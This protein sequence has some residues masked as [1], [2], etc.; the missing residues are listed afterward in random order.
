MVGTILKFWI[1]FQTIVALVNA[2][3]ITENTVS[4]GEVDLSAESFSIAPSVF[5]TILNAEYASLPQSVR[6]G[7]ESGFYIHANSDVPSLWI[8]GQNSGTLVNDGVVSFSAQ[9]VPTDFNVDLVLL[10]LT[11]NGQFFVS[12]NGATGNG[13]PWHIHG[14]D[15]RNEGMISFYQSVPTTDTVELMG[16]PFENHGDVCIYNRVFNV[17]IGISG[18]GCIQLAEEA[19]IVLHDGS[20]PGQTIQFAPGSTG[21]ILTR[22][23]AEENEAPHHVRGFGE[24]MAISCFYPLDDVYYSDPLVTVMYGDITFQFDIGSGYDGSLFAIVTRDPLNYGLANNAVIYGGPVPEQAASGARCGTCVAFVDAPTD[25]ETPSEPTETATESDT[26]TATETTTESSTKTITESDTETTI[27]SD[28][29]TVTESDEQ[30]TT[31]S[32]TATE[33]DTETTTEWDTE[34]KSQTSSET[35]SFRE[36]EETATQLESQTDSTDIETSL[37][38]ETFAETETTDVSETSEP[39]N[40]S[41]RTSESASEIPSSDSLEVPSETDIPTSTESQPLPTQSVSELVPVPP[42]NTK[43]EPTTETGSDP[44]PVSGTSKSV[45]SDTVTRASDTG[46]DSESTS[47]SEEAQNTSADCPEC[48]Y[49]NTSVT[50]A[51]EEPTERESGFVIVTI[52]DGSVVTTATFERTESCS[53]CTESTTAWTA[54]EHETGSRTDAIT[55]SGGQLTSSILFDEKCSECTEFS[56]EWTT[57]NGAVTAKSGVLI[58]T[59]GSDGVLTTYTS[60][61]LESDGSRSRVDIVASVESGKSATTLTIS[62]DPTLAKPNTPSDAPSSD[63]TG[64]PQD[65]FTTGSQ[66]SAATPA[67]EQPESHNDSLPSPIPYQGAASQR[68][69]SLPFLLV[70][71]TSFL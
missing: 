50:I 54:E 20:Q 64:H 24:G 32:D 45:V 4:V 31:K 69:P 37:E 17:Q 36:P 28:T 55:N 38:S 12:N 41:E 53:E 25:T 47:T 5:W 3:E 10:T 60:E 2:L 63:A 70:F 57:E 71:L 66:E 21:I 46:K 29:E 43:P 8:T 62:D 58:I 19:I 30:T 18:D 49:F 13:N 23:N 1:V 9:Q 40:D 35:E 11:N 42:D 59:T 51:E 26:E 61:K 14:M 56:T 39:T 22:E 33:L 52:T 68:V 65:T 34:T 48:T 27:Q 67:S 15:V 16:N 7:T 6:V 44:E